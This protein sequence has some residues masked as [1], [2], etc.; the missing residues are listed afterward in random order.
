MENMQIPPA[1]IVIIIIAVVFEI[2]MKGFALW[3]AAKANDKNWFIAILLINSVGILPI[4][5]MKFI[6]KEK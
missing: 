2:T 3:K 1:L 6:N 5:Y 4:I